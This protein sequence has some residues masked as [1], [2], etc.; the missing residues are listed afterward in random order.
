MR[1]LAALF[2]CLA[3]PAIASANP[4]ELVGFGTHGPAVGNAMVASDDG[5]S[6]SIYNAASAPLAEERVFGLSYTYGAIALDIDREDPNVLDMHGTSMA[7]TVPFD[8]TDDLRAAA[9]VGVYLPDQF[10]ARVHALPGSEQHLALWDNRP[11]RIVVNAAAALM[12][13]DVLSLGA[14]LTFLADAAGR[15]VDLSIETLPGRTVADAD[16]NVDLPM[17][18]APVFGVLWQ[19]AED[20]RFGARYTGEISLDVRIDI[21]TTTVVPGTALGGEVFV[22]VQ[23]VD[24][25]TPREL[26]LGGEWAPGPWTFA[27][28]LAWQ[29]W[30]TLR[31]LASDVEIAA[32]L[33]IDVTILAFAFPRPNFRDVWMP[34]AGV[35]RRFA[36]EHDRQFALRGGYWFARSPVPDQTGLTSYADAD[37]HCATL[38]IALRWEDW[39]APITAELA[40][41][42]QFAVR[43]DTRKDQRVVPHIPEG[44]FT[45]GGAVWVASV[46]ARVEL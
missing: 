4:T 45:T 30:S 13:G 46:G 23:N 36:L 21:R 6:A 31:Q 9:T 15:G 25:F 12:I 37:R 26:A 19:P 7:M 24:Y 34:R 29:Q 39:G 44:D 20:L 28:E 40:L 18:R 38:G 5:L 11:H 43:R 2:G 41:Q 14:G 16:V 33:G 8:L 32:D 27:L 17:R 1:A 22:S 3:T 35:E 10:I 42:G